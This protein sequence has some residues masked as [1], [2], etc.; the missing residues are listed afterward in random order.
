LKPFTIHANG[1]CRFVEKDI[2]GGYGRVDL[3][4]WR[5]VVK[6]P[7]RPAMRSDHQIVFVNYQIAYR[8]RRQIQLQRLPEIAIVKGN[9]H[10]TLGGCIE[11][12]LAF[13]IFANCI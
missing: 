11:Q 4:Q 1:G 6:D 3:P 13:R 2:G 8:R 10:A 7:E 5:D 12:A 9:I